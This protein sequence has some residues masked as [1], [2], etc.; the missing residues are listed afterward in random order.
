M[1]R[2]DAIKLSC[3]AVGRTDYSRVGKIDFF[4]E[5]TTVAD[6]EGGCYAETQNLIALLVMTDAEYDSLTGRLESLRER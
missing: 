3:A 2:R 1:D 4:G 6:V 5:P